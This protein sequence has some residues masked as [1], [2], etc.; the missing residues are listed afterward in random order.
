MEENQVQE[1]VPVPEEG[2]LGEMEG[3]ES[4][5][6]TTEAGTEGDQESS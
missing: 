2:V 6:E 5:E 1:K 3:K 4:T